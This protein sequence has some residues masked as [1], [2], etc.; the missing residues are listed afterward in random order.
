MAF[1]EIMLRLSAPDGG[2]LAEAKS[3]DVCYGGTE[4]NVLACLSNIGHETKYLSKLPDT[5]IGQAVLNYLKSF[6]IDTSDVLFGGEM[7][8]TYFVENGSGSRGSNVIY[9]RRYSEITKLDE[10]SFD[11]DKIFKD[12]ILFH[13]SGISFALSESSRRL[14]F[15]LLEEAKSRGVK[16][17]FDFNYRAKLWSVDEA[18]EVFL[19]IIPKVDIV[20]ASS[21]DLSVFLQTDEKGYFEKY[22]SEYLVLRNRTVIS[23]DKHSVNVT[24]YCKR[25]GKISSYATDEI[26][27]DVSEKIGGGDAFDGGMLHGILTNPDDLKAAVNFGVAAFMLKHRVKGD[28]FT[29]SG[30]DIVEFQKKSGLV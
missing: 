26:T 11:F 25:G 1:G 21:L 7:L 2:R 24:A 3:F 20:L 9:N 8:G 10:N 16:I 4:A 15:R 12:V 13:I 27:F 29:L 17:S 30:G 14:A 5:E 19:E 6:K 23:N 18:R 28:V 22:N